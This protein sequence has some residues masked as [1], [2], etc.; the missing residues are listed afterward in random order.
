MYYAQLFFFVKPPKQRRS[1]RQY[2]VLPPF[3]VRQASSFRRIDLYIARMADYG[4]LSHSLK[5]APSKFLTVRPV[6]ACN[7]FATMPQ[8]FSI[9]N[10]SGLV[11]GQ[12]ITVKSDE[13]C[14]HAWFVLAV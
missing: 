11:G 6:L 4:N 9:H 3:S 7:C 12:G 5:I 1:T 8:T 14:S 10:K 2:F 13:L